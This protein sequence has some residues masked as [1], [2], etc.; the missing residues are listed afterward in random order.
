VAAFVISLIGGALILAGALVTLYI[1][2][3]TV[4]GGVVTTLGT[5]FPGLLGLATGP[6]IMLLAVLFYRA[7]RHPG[8]YG[9]LI[10]GLSLVSWLSFLGGL[11][12]GLTLGI[13]GGILILVWRPSSNPAGY[14]PTL[15]PYPAFRTCP[16]CGRAVVADAR[17]CSYCGHT[18][19]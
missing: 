7:P 10:I 6:A 16:Q 14:Y 11:F 2:V 12:A 8:L 3:I 5:W 19:T 9:S 18:F 1:L 15:A 13:V 4:T 17:F